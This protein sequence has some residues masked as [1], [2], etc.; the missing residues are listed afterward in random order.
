MVSHAEAATKRN[1]AKMTTDLRSIPCYTLCRISSWTTIGEFVRAQSSICVFCIFD[2]FL[3]HF[4]I[5]FHKFL[6]ISKVF[7]Y[8]SS[9]S[10]SDRHRHRVVC[11]DEVRVSWS[12]CRNWFRA[13]G[14]EETGKTCRLEIEETGK[15]CRS[16][17][18]MKLLEK[19]VETAIKDPKT[20]T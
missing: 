10:E 1:M 17:L 13:Q 15:T 6:F 12:R 5:K 7:L 4:C 19:Y 9:E 8:F 18:S 11:V 20:K 14:W 3:N 16:R 2:S